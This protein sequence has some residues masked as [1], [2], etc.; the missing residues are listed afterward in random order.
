ML[1]VG[2]TQQV[3]LGEVSSQQ[4]LD[5]LA[6]A[7]A[8]GSDIASK[9][10]LE[11]DHKAWEK[12]HSLLATKFCGIGKAK[13]EEELTRYSDVSSEFPRNLPV[14]NGVGP[15]GDSLLHLAAT[16]GRRDVVGELCKNASYQDINKQNDQGETALLQATR[17]G[18]FDTVEYL[19][20]IGASANLTTSEDENPLH[21]L[22]SFSLQTEEE[23]LSLAEKMIS[24]GAILDQVCQQ[25]TVYNPHFLHTVGPGTPLHR[26]VQRNAYLAAKVLVRLGAN[27]YQ[28][29]DNFPMALACSMHMTRFISLFLESEIP[30]RLPGWHGTQGLWDPSHNWEVMKAKWQGAKTY[31]S[32]APSA[33]KSTEERGTEDSLLGYA[34]SPKALH[35]RMALHGTQY[36]EQMQLAVQ[37]ISVL[38]SQSFDRV[39]WDYQSALMHSIQSRD[40]AIVSYLVSAFPN[41]TAQSF[42]NPVPTS[43]G[44]RLPIQYALLLG[45]WPIFAF[46]LQ[47]T[48]PS[49]PVSLTRIEGMTDNWL[50]QSAL[51][52]FT[53][54]STIATHKVSANFAN[55]IHLAA[56]AH[57][58][59]RF[60][61]A[62]LS[63]LPADEARELVNQPGA[64]DELPLTMAACRHFFAVGDVLLK[65]G[66]DIDAEGNKPPDGQG[67]ARSCLGVALNFNNHGTVKAASWLLDHGAGFLVNKKHDVTALDMAIRSGGAFEV[68]ERSPLLPVRLYRENTE[69]LELV[70]RH[71]KDREMVNHRWTEEKGL[72]GM[73]ALHWAIIRM[74]PEAVRLLLEAGA[75]PEL[76]MRLPNGSR[77]VSARELAMGMDEDTIP[78]EV[79][80][81]GE[82]E[83]KRFL[84]RF[85]EMKQLFS[86][87]ISS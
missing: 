49:T 63:R 52:L 8:L 9:H 51:W 48:G 68:S 28:P 14:G 65:Y 60:I 79:K 11:L 58:D 73:T 87:D 43:I 80:E 56:A 1:T 84:R 29:E 83:V 18:H 32:A 40:I 34:I 27:P 35:Y 67:I 50:S 78:D 23:I 22:S 72:Y 39:S 55:L 42:T 70:L 25:N 59:P 37:Q 47:H 74:Q 3:D 12:A 69:V 45:D 61:E 33:W 17:S 24:N 62:I 85:E 57:P 44:A 6:Q 41:E 30:I 20:S 66:A 21:W 71:F 5:W 76:E 86:Q 13:F 31:Q 19:L 75:D 81:K 54:R 4:C 46:L 64:F 77:T 53:R 26:A 7:T 36:L 15:G 2:A 10:L 38:E 16:L 82:R